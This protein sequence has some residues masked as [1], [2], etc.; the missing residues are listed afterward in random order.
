MRYIV[1]L[2][3]IAAIVGSLVVL[4]GVILF[5]EGCPLVE[6][7]GRSVCLWLET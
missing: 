2:V 4:A 3:L 1:R 6:Y 7:K 5:D